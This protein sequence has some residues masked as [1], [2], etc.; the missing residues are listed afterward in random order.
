MVTNSD[1][2]Q[3][4]ISKQPD[5]LSSRKTLFNFM[6]FFCPLH[7]ELSPK[8][9]SNYFSFILQMSYWKKR[10]DQALAPL[11]ADLAEFERLHHLPFGSQSIQSFK[12]PQIIELENT[13]DLKAL[14]RQNWARKDLNAQ[15]K[16]TDL[17][18]SKVMVIALKSNSEVNVE[19][20]N[21]MAFLKD[22]LLSA[23]LPHTRL[24]YNKLMELKPGRLQLLEV[25]PMTLAGF[26]THESSDQGFFLE[27]YQ[28]EQESNFKGSL[29][30][31]TRIYQALKSIEASF[32]DL[33]TDPEYLKITSDLKDA[34]MSLRANHSLG[35]IKAQKAMEQAQY[36]LKKLFPND[37]GIQLL[38]SELE[39]SLISEDTCL[40]K[41][42]NPQQTI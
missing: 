24:S 5:E 1:F 33:G 32:I 29:E 22:G 23:A 40:L 15:L 31:Q 2:A 11:L 39:T 12:L 30:V 6:K 9:L 21:C 3:F 34:I 37:K 36:S 28:L 38:V 4:L 19:I 41:N 18:N 17:P 14:I 35:L 13:D 42:L 20:Y 27:G 10:K 16:F 7:E 26:V 25:A 8:T